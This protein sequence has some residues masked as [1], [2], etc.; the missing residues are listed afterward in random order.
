MVQKFYITIIPA[1]TVIFLL[2][3]SIAAADAKRSLVLE[4]FDQL[5]RRVTDSGNVWYGIGNIRLR[6]DSTYISS[7][8][9]V[10]L[11]DRNIIHFFGN[12]DAYDSAQQIRAEQ[13]SYYH[14]DSVMVAQGNVVLIHSLDSIKAES[15]TAEFDRVVQMVSLDGDPRLYL[16]YPDTANMVE[17][18]ADYLTFYSD[19]RNG[20][21]EDNVV[22]T[23]QDTRATC[24]CAEFSQQENLLVLRE[25][26]R[27]VRD[28]SNI[29]GQLMRILLSGG[30]VQEIE[31]FD[32]ATAYFIEGDDSAS[33]EFSGDTKLSGDNIK[34]Y[35]NDGEIRKIAAMG[36]A[37][38]EYYPSP[39]DTTGA[40]K[41][42]VSGDTIFI[43]VANR[44]ITKAEIKGGAEGI[45]IT[46]SDR[47]PDTAMSD[48][49]AMVDGNSPDSAAVDTVRQVMADSLALDSSEVAS[50]DTTLASDS[51]VA[52]ITPEDS[53]LYNGNFLEYFAA[54]RII[55]ITGDASVLQGEV[56][57]KADRVDYDVPRRVVLAT[58]GADTVD[59]NV[60]LRPLSLKDGDEEI[61]GSQMV[62]N[63]DTKKGKIENATTKYEMAYYRGQ[64][65]FKEDDEIFYVE[66]GKL[67]SCDLEEPHFHFRCKKMKLIHNDRVIARPVT[68]YIE[69]IPTLTIPYYI[70]PLKRGR[71]SGMLPIKLG[72][73]E[74]GSR[75]IGNLGYYW[76]ASEYWDLQTSFDYYENVGITLN[77]SFR[78]N[79]R[80]TY[81]GSVR[82]SYSRDRQE[83]AFSETK[84]DR[85][86]LAGNHSQTFPYEIDFR[87]S[88]NF[89][90]DKNYNTDFSNDPDERRNRNITSKANFN[91][92]FGRSSV[93]LSFSHV[94]NLDDDSRNSSLPTGSFTMPSFHP[95]GSGREVDG[96]TVKSWYNSF[97]VG[98]RNSFG[99]LTSQKYLTNTQVIDDS[100]SVETRTRTWKDFGYLDHSFSLSAP[101][102]LF[103]YLTLGPSLSMQETWY[104]IMKSDQAHTAGIPAD[105]SYRRGA[106]S[107]S[108]NSNTDLYGTFNINQLGLVA[109][110]HV[111]SPSVSFGWSPAITK[112]DPVKSFTGRGGGGGKSKRLSF[113]LQNLFQA[114]VKSGESEKKIDLMRVSSNLSYN[115]EAQEKKF[116]YLST[117]IS[118]TLLK[119]VSLRGSLSHD[120][121]D[122]NDELN[123]RSPSLRSFN[124][125]GSF[126]ARGSVADDYTR[127]GLS[128]DYVKDSLG[129]SSGSGLNADLSTPVPDGGSGGSDWN[130]NVSY[131]YSESRSH[132]ATTSRTHWLQYTFNMGLTRYWKFKYSQRYDF[133][134]HESID[135]MVDL[136][137][138]M[139]CWEAHFYWIPNGSR[140]GYYFKINVIAIPDI[141]VEK[142]ESG[143]R[144]ALFNR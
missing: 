35:F 73:F 135:K 66:N 60:Q 43:Y 120:L 3:S 25:E 76:A 83:S 1:L 26:P 82:A 110:R 71:H 92:R 106:I 134:R 87:G 103:K 117:S 10:W 4:N 123:W 20:E 137:R 37:R 102:K 68:L 127:Q 44:R 6:L 29:A 138:K 61:F 90:S 108:M 7:D 109:L 124:V 128:S 49:M 81:N 14:Q 24:G 101:Q 112:N 18:T 57:L 45:Y 144:G 59:S 113:G 64:D 70:F 111:I 115:F 105:R 84:R 79:K 91:K 121:Y 34:F 50:S 51:T 104:Y 129:L 77:N 69:T 96:Q 2:L 118:S 23:H 8:S 67:S 95:F 97:Y 141:K 21:A 30:G 52:F 65:L 33:G 100:T 143:L 5:N 93:S 39:D 88:G 114:K 78:Y 42:F 72:N 122:Q 19:E 53:I 119:N 40:G 13:L 133:V 9:L 22:I 31:V 116:S 62:F 17:I 11:R 94:N 126:Q 86:R 130:V 125:S 54:N 36:A 74:Q 46:E 12:V 27:A 80:Y 38:S 107:A 98:Y 56:S 48:S 136:Y 47:P 85:W 58:A 139:H 132:G 99:I 15:Q 75:F 142:S 16:N 140:Q 32:D 55:R 41:N 63:V 131:S 28:S 89:V